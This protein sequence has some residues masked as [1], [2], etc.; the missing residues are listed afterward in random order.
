MSSQANYLVSPKGVAVWPKIH[1][2]DFKFDTD[3]AFSVDLRVDP[4][5]PEVAGFLDEL[6]RR[7]EEHYAAT[8]QRE[9][10]KTLK[11]A[12]MPWKPEQDDEG[13]DTGM[14]LIRFK[15]RHKV[16]SKRTGK[17]YFYQPAVFDSQRQI[18]TEP[19]GGGSILRV[20]C[21]PYG[22]YSPSLGCGLRLT[23]A[24]VQVLQLVPPGGGASAD[25]FEEEE[26]YVASSATGEF[27]DSS[28]QGDY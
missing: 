16:T 27:E 21:E 10:K 17:T 20:K 7:F 9:G 12:A 24:A 3:G 23:M 13:N 15:R 1:E 18:M 28:E 14:V 26:G 19:I 22:W 11:R 2:P 4:S 25:G 6:G 8:C 5:L